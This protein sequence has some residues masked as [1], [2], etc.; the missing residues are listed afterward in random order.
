[1]GR[2]VAVTVAL[3]AAGLA[4]ATGA[5]EAFDLGFRD[6]LA[7]LP[8]AGAPSSERCGACHEE[9]AAAWRTSRHHA[10]WTNEVM[11]AGFLDEPEAFCVH[12]HAPRPEQTA[13]ILGHRGWYLARRD[14]PALEASRPAEPLAAEG[15]GCVACHWRDGEV[16]AADRT[17]A[18]PHRVRETAALTDGTLCR[19]CHE[20]AMPRFT[21]GRAELT[22]VPMQT[23][24]TEWRA[25][26]AAGGE[27]TCVSC[28]MPGGAHTFRGAWDEVFLRASLA[29]RA[30]PGR[31]VLRS[32]G[33]GH[34]LPTGDLFRHLTID[35]DTGAGWVTLATIGR[36]YAVAADAAAGVADKRLVSDTSLRPGEVREVPLPD[37]ARWRVR[38]HY[39]KGDAPSVV[40]AAS[41]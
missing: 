24:Y 26:V 7:P 6:G 29:V 20:F 36:T 3:L 11:R 34:H 25:Y 27:G 8:I 5:A 10:A 39:A 37:G 33:V 18:A 13:E 1:M 30:E 32:V 9:E 12:C 38:Y 23:T 16:L 41:P 4:G 28:H 19:G 15:V 40:L 35:A 21:D 14:A 17:G 22:D 31:L 2:A